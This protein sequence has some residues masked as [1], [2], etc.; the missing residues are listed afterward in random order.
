[1][2]LEGTY[3]FAIGGNDALAVGVLLIREDGSIVGR[4]QGDLHYSGSAAID[5]STGWITLDLISDVLV[6]GPA[7][8]DLPHAR[9]YTLHFPPDFGGG[10]PVN[11]DTPPGPVHVMVHRATDN[12]APAALHGFTI[13]VRQE[14]D[15]N[16]LE[17][18]FSRSKP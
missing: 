5:A 14:E 6:Q 7:P 9:H 18:G 4:D 17:P 15:P 2:A 16:A 8:Q 10:S 1:M 3:T 12:Y 11:V 13:Q